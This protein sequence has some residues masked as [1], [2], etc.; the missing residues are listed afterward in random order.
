MIWDPNYDTI[1][2]K[3]NVSFNRN[4]VTKRTILS[5][6]S[7][8]YDPLGLIGPAIILAKI[9]IQHL[10]KLKIGWDEELSNE[11]KETWLEFI[12][13]IQVLNEL[14]IDRQVLKDTPISVEFI[15]FGDSSEKAYGACIYICSTDATGNR[16]VKLLTAKSRVA[17]VKK[18]TLPRLELLAAHL[19][20]ELIEKTRNVLGLHPKKVVYFTDSTIV[21]SWLKVEPSQLKMFAANRISKILKF[22]RCLIVNL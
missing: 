2:Y 15:G 16:V 11:L 5:A 7:Q 13:Q 10:W 22:L 4:K 9:F 21:L 20:A 18:Q 19:L 3:I 1:K 6:I 8:I 17:P 12:S 14:S